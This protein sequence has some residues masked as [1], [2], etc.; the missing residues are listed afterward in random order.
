MIEAAG[1]DPKS[2]GIG[3]PDLLNDICQQTGTKFFAGK[4]RHEAKIGKFD[5]TIA[6]PVKLGVS[7][8]LIVDIQD[9]PIDVGM[10]N[11][12]RK[13]IIRQPAAIAPKPFL[14]NAIIKCTI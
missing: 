6:T 1:F 9:I 10:R 8:R 5:F 11:N 4:A 13:L 12:F 2:P 7:S 3:L 14:A